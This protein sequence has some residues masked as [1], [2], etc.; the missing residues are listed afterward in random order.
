M[1]S[2]SLLGSF[3]IA[4]RSQNAKE[5]CALSFMWTGVILRL[6]PRFTVLTSA[7]NAKQN[8]CDRRLRTNMASNSLLGSFPIAN[9]SQNA[10]EKWAL[11]FMWTGV[12]LRLLPRFT[13]LTSAENAKQNRCDRRL[14]TNM[15][16]NSLLGSFPIA[17]RS[18]NAKE[19]CALSFMWTGV[20][21]R[22]LPRFT[23]LTRAENAKQKRCDRRIEEKWLLIAC[24]AG[25]PLPTGHKMPKKSVHCHSCGLA[26]FCACFLDSQC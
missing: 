25:F 15:A 7:E 3:P 12:I 21:L 23:V 16:S 8:R 10:K 17:N 13:V 18:Q 2:N 5:K 1:A 24:L 4:N 22:L 26:L 11:S 20:I 19:E 14:R 6:L 9:R